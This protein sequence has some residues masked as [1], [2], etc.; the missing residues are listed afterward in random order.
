M[1]QMDGV[2]KTIGGETFKVMMLGPLEAN[3]LLVDI[4]KTLGP[5]L[6]ALL[7]PLLG[8]KDT[9]AAFRQLL[10]GI[11]DGDGGLAGLSGGIERAVTGLIDRI[12][13]DQLREIISIMEGVTTVKKGSEWPALGAVSTILFRGKLK[14]MYQWLG[15]AIKVQFQDFF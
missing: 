9:T 4:G 8:A 11:Q 6:G 2:T 13:K 1:S 7:A 15:F 14:L 5:A 12:E 3:D 10:D